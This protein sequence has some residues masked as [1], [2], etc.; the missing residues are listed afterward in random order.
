MSNLATPKIR[1][2]IYPFSGG[3]YVLD[4]STAQVLNCSVS[5]MLKDISGG[6]FNIVLAPG[7]P[8]GTNDPQ[9]WDRII[10]PMSLCIIEMARGLHA[11]TV[12]VGLVTETTQSEI[13]SPGRNVRRTTRISGMDFMYFFVREQ[14]Y[15]LAAFGLVSSQLGKI[16][17]L[18]AGAAQYLSPSESGTAWYDKVLG[19]KY[20]LLSAVKFSI[21]GGKTA[22]LSDLLAVYFEPYPTGPVFIPVYLNFLLEQGNWWGKFLEIFPYPIYELLI[23]NAPVGDLAHNIG[24][25]KN[26]PY[27]N[28]KK[29]TSYVPYGNIS[30]DR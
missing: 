29:V 11:Q 30:T 22:S 23:L 19:G 24:T 7:G 26:N 14:Y 21:S 25:G 3:E 1:I 28:F 10:T 8:T 16:G 4:G 9:T 15:T 18:A 2:R 5:K 17:G 27:T 13:W 6:T 12:M 20:G